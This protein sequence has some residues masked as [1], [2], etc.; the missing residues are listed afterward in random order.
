M[1]SQPI[2]KTCSGPLSKKIHNFLIHEKTI[3]NKKTL[4]GR[5]MQLKSPLQ[6]ISGHC[7]PIIDLSCHKRIIYPSVRKWPIT[8]MTT[9][10]TSNQPPPKKSTIK[11]L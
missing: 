4:K 8:E 5:F 11:M 3:N 10:Q 7:T 9:A 1:T 6:I 2:H